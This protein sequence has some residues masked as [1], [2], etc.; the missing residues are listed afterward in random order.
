LVRL[1]I[2][3]SVQTIMAVQSS[4]SIAADKS[5]NVS[6]LRSRGSSATP[7]AVLG[8]D[9][10]GKLEFLG[11]DGVTWSESASIRAI[12]DETFTITKNGTH[13]E[14]YTTPIGTVTD[15]EAMRIMDNGFIGIG[16]TTP[17]ALLDVTGVTETDSLRVLAGA[18][19]AGDVLTSDVL[20]NATWQAPKPAINFSAN[21]SITSIPD[22]NMTPLVF[23]NV[24]YN[25]GGNF[26]IASGQFVASDPGVYHVDATIT[27]DSSINHEIQIHVLRNGGTHKVV[28][29][30]A[31]LTKPSITAHISADIFL[32]GFNSVSI[33]IYQNSGGVIVPTGSGG[34]SKVYFTGHLVK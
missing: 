5:S 1:H 11:W 4:N 16:T 32:N 31:E 34:G 24:E 23:D 18:G 30:Y 7:T 10:L 9:R 14:F 3:D 25:N 22:I 15:I 33:G 8:G 21:S 6:F 2:V 26:N 13:L 29:V 28:T 27:F 19:T 20:G 17:N 12:A